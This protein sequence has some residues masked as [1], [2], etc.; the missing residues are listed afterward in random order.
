MKLVLTLPS[1]S[2]ACSGKQITFKAP[3]NSQAVSAISVC[4]V[5]YSIVNASGEAVCGCSE[6]AWVEGAM[7]SVVLDTDTNKAYVQNSNVIYAANVMLSDRVSTI[8]DCNTVSDA[9]DIRFEIEQSSS[10]KTQLTAGFSPIGLAYGNGIYVAV[11]G[12]T[13]YDYSSNKA[14]YSSDGYVWNEAELPAEN[15]TC[16]TYGSGE[17]VAMSKDSETYKG[18]KKCIV[19]YSSDGAT[20][21]K[22][23]SEFA[24]PYA[25]YGTICYTESGFYVAIS[26]EGSTSVIS[27]DLHAWETRSLPSNSYWTSMCSG[28]TSRLYDQAVAVNFSGECA[29]LNGTDKNWISSS[30]DVDIDGNKEWRSVCSGP[31]RYVAISPNSV[32]VGVYT[33]E[34]FSIEWTGYKLSDTTY[35]VGVPSNGLVYSNGLFVAVGTEAVYYSVNGIHWVSIPNVETT[36]IKYSVLASNSGYEFVALGGTR[37]NSL[38]L[39][40]NKDPSSLARISDIEALNERL[41]KLESIVLG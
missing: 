28:K 14:F 39:N 2:S 35:F 9:L 8:C 38:V 22:L 12:L 15:W 30:I 25:E 24:P 10:I 33:M 36:D 32:A 17:F 16:I 37:L 41:K 20:W 26:R 1:N 3:C 7:V 23:P 34:S 29:I 6:N 40:F 18:V 19:A 27:K 4:G 11:A 5:D 21:V 31:D 13:N